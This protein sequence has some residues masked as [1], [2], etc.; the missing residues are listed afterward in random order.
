MTYHNNK[1]NVVMDKEMFE[2]RVYTE[3]GEIFITQPVPMED[4][5]NSI[6]ISPE[7]VDALIEWLKEARAE[8]EGKTTT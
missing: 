7:Q 4:A 3:K 8:L 2:I 5:P 6:I 1:G